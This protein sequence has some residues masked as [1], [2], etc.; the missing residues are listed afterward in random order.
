M[1][2]FVPEITT[3]GWLSSL[4]LIKEGALGT[5]TPSDPY[6]GAMFCF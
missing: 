6:N 5:S 4:L 1:Q 3:K 2:K